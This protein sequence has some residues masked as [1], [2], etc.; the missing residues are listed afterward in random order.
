MLGTISIGTLYLFTSYVGQ[1]FDPVNN[2]ATIFARFQQAQASAERDR[3]SL[4]ETKPDIVDS[5]QVVEAKYGTLF[6]MTSAKTFE[7][8][9][10]DVEFRDVTFKYQVGE[11]VL[12]AFQSSSQ[13]RRIDRT[14]WSHRRRQIDDRQLDLPV[15]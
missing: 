5:P 14:S 7:A 13:S 15:L 10:G 4:I 6:D 1:F 11:A 8:L 9:K 2:V 12:T 3:F